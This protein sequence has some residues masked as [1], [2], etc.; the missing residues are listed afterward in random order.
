MARRQQSVSA[1]FSSS[2]SLRE[3][4]SAVDFYNQINMLYGTITE[5]C[6]PTE[7]PIM[8]AGSRWAMILLTS[9]LKGPDDPLRYEYHWQD[10]KDFKRPTKMSA[11]GATWISV[12]HS[13]VGSELTPLLSHR[14]RRPSDE[15]GPSLH[16]RRES[17]SFSHRSASFGQVPFSV[18]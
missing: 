13:R 11:P 8:S 10:G 5:F 7:C 3:A 6:T 4:S 12:R 17:L 2:A 9:K 14:L 15:L 1:V 18:P 16:R